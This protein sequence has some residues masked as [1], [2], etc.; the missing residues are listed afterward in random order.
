MKSQSQTTRERSGPSGRQGVQDDVVGQ[1]IDEQVRPEHEAVVEAVV[2]VEQSGQR[3]VSAAAGEGE[4]LDVVGEGRALPDDALIGRALPELREE[5]HQLG[6]DRPA[7]VAL[8][9]VFDDQLPV[10]VDVVRDRLPDDERA[11]VVA[12]EFLQLA[13]AMLQSRLELRRDGQRVIGQGQPDQ[14]FPDVEVNREET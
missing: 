4:A 5:A 3:L 11:D 1:E 12:P 8:H 2:T 13:K 6:V 10:G 9:E 14:T 7:V